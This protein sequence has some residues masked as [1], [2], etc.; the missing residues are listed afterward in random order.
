MR[1][2]IYFFKRKTVP[3]EINILLW[4]KIGSILA[5]LKFLWK[6]SFWWWGEGGRKGPVMAPF[7][8]DQVFSLENFKESF[9]LA[10]LEEKSSSKTGSSL[11]LEQF[12]V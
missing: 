12:I 6:H 9:K 5:N 1:E 7:C 2:K 8:H 10:I 4:K 3:I 11:P